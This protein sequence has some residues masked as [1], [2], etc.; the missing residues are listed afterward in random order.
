VERVV[1]TGLGVRV[2]QLVT[3]DPGA[4]CCP[5]CRVRSASGKDWVLTRPRDVPSGGGQVAVQWRKR[6]WRCRTEVC[7]RVVH[8][9]GCAGAGRDADHHAAVGRACGGGRGRSASVRGRCVAWGVVADGAACGGDPRGTRRAGAGRGHGRE[10]VAAPAAIRRGPDPP[11]GARSRVGEDVPP[12]HLRG[13]AAF[14]T[15]VGY[16]GG[17]VVGPDPGP[18]RVAA[19]VGARIVVLFGPTAAARYG[20]DPPSIDLQ[21]LPGCPH[22]R[23]T[24][25]TEQVC[26]W[27]ATCPLA[28]EGPACMADLAPARVVAAVLVT[29]GASGRT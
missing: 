13:L 23:P 29:L 25:I 11:R 17:A 7:P 24:T 15:A 6:R 27:N 20:L 21:G 14:C 5:V 16:R 12:L 3:D 19:A 1:L 2:V 4:A 28:D 8:R 22:R 10:G 26:W 9:A 18:V